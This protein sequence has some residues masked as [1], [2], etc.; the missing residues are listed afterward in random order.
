MARR[1]RPD[2]LEATLDDREAVRL[3]MAAALAE[4]ED[5]RRKRAPSGSTINGTESEWARLSRRD[6]LQ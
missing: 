4:D 5:R 3:A 2:L 6:A 1:G